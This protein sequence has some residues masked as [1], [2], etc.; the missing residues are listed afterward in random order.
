M[1]YGFSSV[2]CGTSGILL[3]S[4]HEQ[5]EVDDFSKSTSRLIST[6]RDSSKTSL[7][8]HRSKIQLE[9]KLSTGQFDTLFYPIMFRNTVTST[10]NLQAQSLW[11]SVNFC[12]VHQQNIVISL[13]IEFHGGIQCEITTEILSCADVVF[14]FQNCNILKSG[15][16]CFL[17]YCL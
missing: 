8:T 10:R 6:N 17:E 7:F 4:R 15:C 2:K 13:C 12:R 5:N 3:V 9:F 11:L 16:L 14:G 1:F